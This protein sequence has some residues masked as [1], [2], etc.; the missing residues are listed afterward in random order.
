MVSVIRLCVALLLAASASSAL[1]Q[2]PEMPAVPVVEVV[3]TALGPQVYKAHAIA[4]HGEPKFGPD[5][6]HFDYV[7]PGAP[8]GGVLRL[9]ASGTF[10]SFHPYIPKG[11]SGPTGS[12]ETLLTQ[13]ADEPFT[14]YG[15]IAETI[16]WPEDRSWVTFTLHPEARWHDGRPITVEDVIWTLE[17]L[18]TK[19]APIYRFYY[20]DVERAEKVGERR[21][22]FSFT[23][24]E[25]RELP[26]IV[27]QMPV[28]P[29]HY[30]ETRDFESTTLEPPLGSG[31]YRVKDFEAARYIVLE[32]VEDYW[33]EDLPVNRGQDNFDVIRYDYY[34]DPTVIRQAVKAGKVDIFSENSAKEWTQSYEGRALDEGFLK[35]EQFLDKSSGRLQAFYMNTRRPPFDNR[36]LR[37][38]LAYAFDFEWTNRTLYYDSYLHGESFFAPT[39]LASSGLPQGEELEILERYRDRLPPEVFTEPYKP[40]ATDGSGW[41]RDNLRE[42]FR[43]L[44]EAGWEVRDLKMVNKE[45]GQPLRFEFMIQQQSLERVLLPFQ[46]NLARLGIDMRIRFVD[47]SQY[48]NRLREYDFDM[49]VFGVGQALSPGNEQRAYW[50]SAAADQPGSRNISGIKDPVVDELIELVITAPTRESLVART[51]A[52]DRV[53]LWGHYVIPNLVSPYDRIVYWDRFG[54][55]EKVPLNGPSTT[56]WWSDPAK[57]AVVDNWRARTQDVPS[58]QEDSGADNLFRLALLGILLIVA[59]MAFRWAMRRPAS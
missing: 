23:S 42:A 47:T 2:A 13:S 52:L 43:L 31:P 5:F 53:L 57:A 38:A 34:L 1:A 28:L 51:R 25:N 7:N 41:P 35:K 21:V 33:G 32:R 20:G 39:E 48:I 54:M 30:W 6:T 19:G 10:D 8:K 45:T 14:M 44:D 12:V 46:R 3:E 58:A 40:P 26:L 17:T 37:Q 9:S 22:K 56:Y 27:G 49:I 55:P 59:A 11:R 15:L 29:K 18:K 4:M 16:E 36:K 50:G 24:N